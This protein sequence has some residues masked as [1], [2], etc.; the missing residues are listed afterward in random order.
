MPTWFHV[1]QLIYIYELNR[2]EEDTL[3]WTT[4]HV[5]HLIEII[6]VFVGGSGL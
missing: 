1:H 2:A 4:F 3:A 6:I 5:Y